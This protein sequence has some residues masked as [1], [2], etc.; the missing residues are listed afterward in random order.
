VEEAGGMQGRHGRGEAV[1]C[2]ASVGEEKLA[3]ACRGGAACRG[4]MVEEKLWLCL[5]D[6]ESTGGFSSFGFIFF[7]STEHGERGRRYF[8]IWFGA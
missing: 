4:G 1:A 7:L 6:R 3:V 5:W 8:H 2:R